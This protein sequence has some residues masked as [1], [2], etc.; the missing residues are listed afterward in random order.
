MSPLLLLQENVRRPNLMV[1]LC[2]YLEM[3]ESQGSLGHVVP[4]GQSS[5]T[6]PTQLW[7]ILLIFVQLQVENAKWKRLETASEF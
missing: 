3:L 4:R 2:G 5:T 7:V 6:S 1:V